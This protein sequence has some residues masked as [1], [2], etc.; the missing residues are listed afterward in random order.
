MGGTHTSSINE[1]TTHLGTFS[2]SIKFLGASYFEVSIPTFDHGPWLISSRVRCILKMMTVTSINPSRDDDYIYKS[3]DV[4][5]CRTLKYFQALIQGIWI[6]SYD[7]IEMSMRMTDGV[8]NEEYYE[9][10]GDSDSKRTDAPA[11]SR[12]AKRENQFGIL[13]NYAFYCQPPFSPIMPKPTIYSLITKAGGKGKYLYLMILL[14][15][16]HKFYWHY[17]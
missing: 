9:V 4:F 8:A 13:C 17:R 1:Y 3:T 15:H 14:F 10:N 6:V 7:W 2:R 12:K 5:S 11:K 16:L